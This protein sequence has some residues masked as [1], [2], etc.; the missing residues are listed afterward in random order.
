[1]VLEEGEEEPCRVWAEGGGTEH[2]EEVVF[3]QCGCPGG[4]GRL[5]ATGE[6]RCVF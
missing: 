2:E 5:W 3:V 6:S 1:M 4:D